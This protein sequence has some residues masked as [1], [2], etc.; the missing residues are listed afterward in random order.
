MI[1]CLH[2]V[3]KEAKMKCKKEGDQ[4][5]FMKGNSLHVNFNPKTEVCCGLL[6]D[7]DEEKVAKLNNV[8]D[9]KTVQKM[10]VMLSVDSGVEVKCCIYMHQF[11]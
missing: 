3:E 8:N 10:D 4:K 7:L 6:C 9:G 2:L 5:V 11:K 1:E